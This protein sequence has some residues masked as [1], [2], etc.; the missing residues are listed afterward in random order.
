MKRYNSLIE[1]KQV[2]VLYHFTSFINALKIL[3]KN[4][5]IP[6]ANRYISFSRDKNFLNVA[7]FSLGSGSGGNPIGVAIVI[8]GD[9]LSNKYK[10]T[11]YNY[12][13]SS[14]P[15]GGVLT[16]YKHTPE[17]D[18]TEETVNKQITNLNKYIIKLIVFENLY[19]ESFRVTRLLNDI[20]AQN[21]EEYSFEDYVN[22]LK[23]F[24]YKIEI[25]K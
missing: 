24:K 7:R 22:V 15:S 18:E 16:K 23:Q 13:A 6:G 14:E 10:I 12:Y 19:D 25:K 17:E 3:N 4:M 9:K 11:P 8:D 21:K 1:A 20:T 5:L 2:G